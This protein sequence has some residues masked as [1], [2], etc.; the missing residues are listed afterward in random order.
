MNYCSSCGEPTQQDIKF[1]GNC[2]EKINSDNVEE[3]NLVET[4]K[5]NLKILTISLLI[6]ISFN[7]LFRPKTKDIIGEKSLFDLALLIKNETYPLSMYTYTFDAL[8]NYFQKSK[9]GVKFNSKYI[10][11]YVIND[12][13][14]SFNEESNSTNNSETSKTKSKE[15]K[16]VIFVEDYD[17]GKFKMGKTITVQDAFEKCIPTFKES[18]LKKGYILEYIDN[19]GYKSKYR[20]EYYPFNQKIS[21]DS[22]YTNDYYFKLY[23]KENKTTSEPELYK[24]E[25]DLYDCKIGE[26]EI[27]EEVIYY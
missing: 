1:C 5:K 10:F 8:F 7:F 2:G 27:G 24:V 14:S 23:K 26:I 6:L 13:T 11:R 15:R 9:D 19:P 16:N 25:I 17:D 21:I 22:S 12:F 20:E 4:K 18:F 3:P